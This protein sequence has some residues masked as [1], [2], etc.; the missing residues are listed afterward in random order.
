ME[1]HEGIERIDYEYED[2]GFIVKGK[3]SLEISGIV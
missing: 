2:V 3:G 1:N